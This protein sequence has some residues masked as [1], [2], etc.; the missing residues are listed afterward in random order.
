MIEIEELR[1]SYNG[2][3]AL[4]GFSLLVEEG[5]LFGLVGPNGAGKTTLIKILSTLLPAD[6]G[7][8]RIAG[9]DVAAQPRAVTPL[10]RALSDVP[11]L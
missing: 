9:P 10:G 11:G 2:R 4:D 8:A 6:G 3:P 1:K 7:R 5:E